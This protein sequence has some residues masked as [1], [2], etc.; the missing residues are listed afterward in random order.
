MSAHSEPG[1]GEAMV[2]ASPDLS[3][4][5]PVQGSWFTLGLLTIPEQASQNQPFGQPLRKL[6]GI[7]CPNQL[8]PSPGRSRQ[9]WFLSARSVLSWGDEMWHQLI[10]NT[11]SASLGG[12]DCAPRLAREMP[13]LWGVPLEKVGCWTHEPSPSLLIVALCGR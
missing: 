6:C 5:S 1:P 9:L 13:V 3:L 2:T 12:W 7:G 4:F 10:Q 8:L 11:I